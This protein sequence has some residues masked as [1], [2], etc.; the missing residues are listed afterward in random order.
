MLK[1]RILQGFRNEVASDRI[2][3]YAKEALQRRIL[4]GLAGDPIFDAVHQNNT[5]GLIQILKKRKRYPFRLATNDEKWTALHVAAS[6][7]EYRKCLELL[8]QRDCYGKHGLDY[9]HKQTN[10][11]ETALHIACKHGC[12][13][14]VLILLQRGCDPEKKTFLTG[15]AAL[16]I[17]AFNGYMKI[18]R[19]LLNYRANIDVKNNK[20]YTPLHLAAVA[21]HYDITG[22]LLTNG[23]NILS[24][25]NDGNLPL[26]F[27]CEKGTIDIVCIL[28]EDNLTSLNYQNSGGITPFMFAISNFNAHGIQYLLNIGARTDICDKLDRMALHFATSLSGVDI[29]SLL[30]RSTCKTY[31]E[32]YCVSNLLKGLNYELTNFMY[33]LYTFTC[34]TIRMGPDYLNALLD[35]HLPKSVLQM[36]LLQY[37]IF[38][39]RKSRFVF[40]PLA[41]LFY[42]F[43]DEKTEAFDQCLDLLLKH[44]I[45]MIDEFQRILGTNWPTSMIDF[46]HPFSILI[47]KSTWSINKE[48]Y[49]NLLI[50]NN[51]STDY[52]LQ[53]Y[54]DNDKPFSTFYKYKI[55]YG[56]V[57][58]AIET[59]NVEI[60]KLLIS[61]STIL[62]PDI[63]CNYLIMGYSKVC[64]C[65]NDQEKA[66]NLY[67]Y[68]INLKP[69]YHKWNPQNR[70]YYD[71]ERPR[72]F[73]PAAEIID[74]SELVQFYQ[75]VNYDFQKPPLCIIGGDLGASWMR[76]RLPLSKFAYIT[77]TEEFSSVTLQQLCRTA[78]RKQ[79]REP[80]LGDNLRNFGRKILELPL[81]NSLKDYLLFKK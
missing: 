62:E 17:A 51:I 32:Q 60:V 3:Q 22:I 80:T 59:F 30:L 69:V 47:T 44:K 14:N 73:L 5:D 28:L 63:L 23:A 46:V 15:D 4:K 67:K 39:F 31:A 50:E 11:G 64:R 2:S 21:G 79:L 34:L 19:Y 53:C 12:E 37:D 8:L 41:Y 36:P 81:P 27:A 25:D 71:S 56:P 13:E 9:R 38:V 7:S 49:F 20:G 1:R 55:Y 42:H 57:I 6:K 72:L 33:E 26:H 61:N 77:P 16:H 18:V 76:N 66:R 78:I 43:M 70:T 45:T 54:H 40:S 74:A 48:H 52:C 10:L 24:L 35:S 58:Y 75:S 29:F 68:L 65:R